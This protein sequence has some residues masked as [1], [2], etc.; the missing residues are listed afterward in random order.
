MLYT[1]P[2]CNT[3]FTPDAKAI[4]RHK[5]TGYEPC[6]SKSCAARR[7]AQP[8]LERFWAKVLKTETCWLWTAS[9]SCVDGYGHFYPIRGHTICAH[10]FSWELHYGPIPPDLDCCH[11]CDTPSCV[12]PDHLFLGTRLD[13]ME[14]ARQKGRI[15]EGPAWQAHCRLYAAR[16]D[17]HGLRKHPE[18]AARGEK[19]GTAQHTAEEIQA[20]RAL[21]SSMTYT[22][23]ARRFNVTPEYVGKIIRRER[24]KHLP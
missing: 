12:R 19:V 10:R 11:D 17:N 4:R 23:I 8:L 2:Q 14:D 3:L 15:H 1:C 5:A 18:R 7:N 9:K 20:M 22:A 13:N 21:A 24:W 16:G 6:C